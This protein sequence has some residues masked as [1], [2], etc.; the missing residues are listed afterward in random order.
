MGG[1]YLN[2]QIWDFGSSNIHPPFYYSS[3]SE[4]SD[5]FQN[6]GFA[7]GRICTNVRVGSVIGCF[8]LSLDWVTSLL[9]RGAD[10]H[11]LAIDWLGSNKPINSQ[12]HTHICAY[13]P[14]SKSKISEF[15]YPPHVF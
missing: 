15:K 12:S 11:R 9:Y 3:N 10:V 14:E 2:F 4:I 8:V 13:P 5:F 7:V 1:G 6:F